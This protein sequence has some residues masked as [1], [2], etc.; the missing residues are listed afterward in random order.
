MTFEEQVAAFVKKARENPEKVSRSVSIKLFS[1]VILA[2]PVD[3][4]RLRINW[5]ASGNTPASGEVNGADKLGSKSISDAKKFVSNAIEW[6]NF[7]LTNNLTYAETIEYGGYTGG[8]PNTTVDGY[9]TQAPA[10]M[11]R[12][13]VTRFQRLINEA[14]REVT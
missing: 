14:L 6:E 3:T 9:S 7:T 13:N 8:G 12:V 1:A 2:T 5:Q 10:G 11:V 4:G